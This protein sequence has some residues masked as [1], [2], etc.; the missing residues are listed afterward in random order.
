MGQPSMRQAIEGR[1]IVGRPSVGQTFVDQRFVDQ[2]TVGQSIEGQRI[3]LGR[4]CM[5]CYTHFI[6]L[7]PGSNMYVLL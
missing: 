1:P 6:C 5:S 2:S 4:G 7:R 3:V